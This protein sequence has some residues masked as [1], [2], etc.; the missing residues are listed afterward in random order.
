MTWRNVNKV[1]QQ[2]DCLIYFVAAYRTPKGIQYQAFKGK[3]FLHIGT[4]AECKAA[5]E[6]DAD[7]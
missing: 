7:A 2:S 1:C 3:A 6:A 5:C 4:A